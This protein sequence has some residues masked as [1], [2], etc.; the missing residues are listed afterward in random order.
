MIIVR[1]SVTVAPGALA[2]AI[3]FANEVVALIKATNGVD[4]KIAVPVGGN[5]ARIAFIA[6][7]ENLAQYETAS[8][9]L[10]GSEKYMELIKKVAGLVVPDTLHDEIWRTL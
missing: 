5:A 6:N 3:S 9:K 7:Y 2:A 4:V 10:L 8:L 1:R